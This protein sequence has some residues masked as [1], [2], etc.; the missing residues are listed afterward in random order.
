[1]SLAEGLRV[2]L[3]WRIAGLHDSVADHYLSKQ[4]SELQWIRNAIQVWDIGTVAD[5]LSEAHSSLGRADRIALSR[6]LWV[7]EQRD[8][9]VRKAHSEHEDLENDERY[10]RRLLMVSAGLT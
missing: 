8:Y 1:R 4:E 3:F 5:E 6:T 10:I 7:R 9:Y 2:Q